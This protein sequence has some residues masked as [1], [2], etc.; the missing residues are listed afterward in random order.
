MKNEN[1]AISKAT[2]M[3]HRWRTRRGRDSKPPRRIM[4]QSPTAASV[5]M[6]PKTK[7]GTA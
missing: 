4:R 5:A 3:R 2:H 7:S 6:D 1:A